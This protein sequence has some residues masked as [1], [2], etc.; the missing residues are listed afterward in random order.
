MLPVKV[1]LVHD[2]ITFV[3]TMRMRLAKRDLV[4]VPAYDGMHALQELKQDADIDIVILDPRIPGMDG[5]QIVRKIKEG[6]PLVEII[7]LTD[8]SGIE[9]AIEGMTLGAY[10]YLVKPCDIEE[11]ITKLA[12]AEAR[13]AKQEEK[14]HQA[15]MRD[16][17][18]RGRDER[19]RD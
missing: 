16:I 14:I 8:Q 9:T 11:L 18:L 6:H 13:K 3:E 17:A 10:D 4:V 12:E 2:E 15:R 5:L 19:L 7:I 1:M